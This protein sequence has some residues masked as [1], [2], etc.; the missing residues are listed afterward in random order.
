MMKYSLFIFLFLW[1][2]WGWGQAQPKKKKTPK[3]ITTVT[4]SKKSKLPD[5]IDRTL[6]LKLAVIQYFVAQPDDK[7]ETLF[8]QTKGKLTFGIVKYTEAQNPVFKELF[9][10]QY[11]E[12]YKEYILMIS[13]GDVAATTTFMQLLVRHELEYRALLTPEQLTLYRNAFQTM[14]TSNR[15]TYDSYT[16]LFF[17]DSLL[18]AYQN[19]FR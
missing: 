8:W 14:E 6:K 11:H 16:G 19:G 18:Q 17:S 2:L 9:I 13:Q 1:P 5:E 4:H 7:G 3:T 15:Q 10:K 12:M